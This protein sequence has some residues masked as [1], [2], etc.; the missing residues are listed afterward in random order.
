MLAEGP[1]GQIMLNYT[2]LLCY[3]MNHTVIP[4]E[5]SFF[6]CQMR[7]KQA[8]C[9]LVAGDLLALGNLSVIAQGLMFPK[10]STV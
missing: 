10:E 7:P 9:T 6:Y 4:L 2:V 5:C 8:C 1:G 3:V